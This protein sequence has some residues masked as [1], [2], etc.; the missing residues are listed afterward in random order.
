M[1]GETRAPALPTDAVS[2]MVGF[3][4]LA[5]G[6]CLLHAHLLRLPY[7]WDEA[8]YFIPAAR[9][10]LLSGDPI[11]HS[12]P[13]NAHPPLIMGWLV[14]AWA[15]FG[16]APVVTRVAMLM[17][18]CFGLLG[19][20]RLGSFL[21][22]RMT[23]AAAVLCVGLYPVYFAQSSL[24]QLDLPAAA[25]T[26]WALADYLEGKVNWSAAMFTLAALAKET[27]ILAPLALLVW[28][29]F[30]FRRASR[31]GRQIHRVLVW[32]CVVLVLW[33]AWHYWRVGV[34]ADRQYVQYNISDTLNLRRALGAFV[35]QMWHGFAYMNLFVLTFPAACIWLFGRGATRVRTAGPLV[36]VCLAYPVALSWVGGASLARYMLPATSLAIVLSLAILRAG[37]SVRWR[38]L[39]IA[40]SA[41]AFTFALNTYPPYH[42]AL[43]D[44]LAWRD[45]VQLQVDG[46][47]FLQTSANSEPVLTAWP[48]LDE[49]SH[50]WLGYTDRVLRAI[51]VHDFERAALQQ[52]A[53]EP[54]RTAFIFTLRY[55]PRH[56]V[57]GPGSYLRG[58]AFWNRARAEFFDREPDLT[59]GL[60]AGALGGSIVWSETRGAL[61]AAVIENRR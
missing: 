52:G 14:A 40:V 23:G 36:A 49:I 58:L 61:Q 56:S 28:E 2:L 15:L 39:A 43:D 59:P 4:L 45:F 54:F 16:F 24:A 60:A 32:P 20:W 17:V 3:A 11:A 10:W 31:R 9:D 19:A 51:P 37:V 38:S 1:M 48:A 57:F 30:D 21:G 7:F 25:I 34:F 27:A 53:R 42:F 35:V 44:N 5:A 6:N 33:F 50:P 8:G 29:G 46:T 18:S 13:S 55:E 12:V 41:A 22:G 47:H 26:M